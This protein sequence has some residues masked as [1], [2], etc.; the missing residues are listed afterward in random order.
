MEEFTQEQPPASPPARPG[1]L[2]VLCI[3]TFIGSGMQLFSSLIIATFYDMF[4]EVAGEFA[5]KFKMPGLDLLRE[6]KPM[7]FVVT[8]ILYAGSLAGAILMMRLKKTGFHIYTIA[9]ILL[10]IAPMYYMHLPAPGTFEILFSGL[11]IMLYSMN[12]KHMT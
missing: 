2:T 9:Q 4:V 10:I 6:V 3:L 8:A 5:E 7:F 12:L 1:M 11:F